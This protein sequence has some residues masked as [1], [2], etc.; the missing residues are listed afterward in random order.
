[1][2]TPI[3]DVRSRDVADRGCVLSPAGEIDHD[4]YAL[5]LT[6]VDEAIAR[7]R[8]QLVVDLTEVTFCDSGGLSAFIDT[9][10]R[11]A[12]RGGWFRLAGAP[13][14]VLMILRATNLDRYLSLYTTV[15]EATA[16]LDA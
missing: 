5:F 15:G 13:S 6:T 16:D 1:M 14:S 3:L 11:A 9:H 2:V 12:A 8:V 10:R 7:G 4:S